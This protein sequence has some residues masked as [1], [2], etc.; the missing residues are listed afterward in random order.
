MSSHHQ[1]EIQP[2]AVDKRKVQAAFD[3]A[4][5]G[6]DEAAV[7]QHEIGQRI[8]D[9]LEFIK[10]EPEIIIDIGSGTGRLSSAVTERYPGSR[11]YSLDLAPEMLNYARKQP[12]TQPEGFICADAEQL[13]FSDQSVDM[14]VSNVTIQWCMNLEQTFKEFHRIIKPGGLLMFTTFGPDTLKELRMSWSGV[15]QY[16]HVNAFF[17]MHDIGDALKRIGFSDPVMDVENFTLTYKEATTLMRDL[18]AVGAHNVT[19]GRPHGL[20]GKQRLQKV[21]KAY[22]QFRLDNGLLPATYEVIYGH[23]WA[24][25]PRDENNMGDT[26]ED[27]SVSIPLSRMRQ[28]MGVKK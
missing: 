15:D 12:I 5:H 9:R 28:R 26:N 18:K 25:L 22:E 20:T 4:A 19:E 27:G 17:D 7:L 24:P 13:P 8:M 21:I 11:L 3:H 1:K 10:I 6:Y 23:A 14:I 2:Y 16:N